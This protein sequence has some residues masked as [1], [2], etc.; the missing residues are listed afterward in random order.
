MKFS[1]PKLKKIISTPNLAQF[2]GQNKEYELLNITQIPFKALSKPKDKRT[3]V[4]DQNKSI[5]KSNYDSQ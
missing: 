2:H 4:I 1:E 3:L 5:F